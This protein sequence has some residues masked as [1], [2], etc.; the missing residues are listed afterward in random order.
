MLIEAKAGSFIFL[1]KLGFLDFSSWWCG[2][3]LCLYS[4]VGWGGWSDEVQ[5]SWLGVSGFKMWSWQGALHF[6]LCYQLQAVV[7]S[8]ETIC[9][10]LVCCLGRS[11]RGI[12]VEVHRGW[13]V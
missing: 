6:F 13:E 12:H 5:L 9:L 7:T 11:C 10:I 1:D 2:F 8:R 3:T 4:G